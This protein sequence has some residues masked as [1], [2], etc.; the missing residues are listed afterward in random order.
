M[1]DQD[2]GLAR[3]WLTRSAERGNFDAMVAL[4][5]MNMA[6]LGGEKDRVEACKWFAIAG[7][8]GHPR[9]NFLLM[10]ITRTM[11]KA[12]KAEAADRAN[13]WLLKAAGR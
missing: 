9:A 11:T 12:Q 2:Y 5:E 3:K 8:Q 10:E 13:T 6:G 4:G 1:V 7:S